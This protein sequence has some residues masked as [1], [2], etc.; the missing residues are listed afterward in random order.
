MFDPFLP[1]VREAPV[2]APVITVDEASEPPLAEPHALQNPLGAL[3]GSET[4]LVARLQVEPRKITV[5]PAIEHVIRSTT[6][7]VQTEVTVRDSRGPVRDLTQADFELFDNGV[8]QRI[9]AFSINELN[10][11]YTPAAAIMLIDRVGAFDSKT[12]CNRASVL[13][14]IL[15]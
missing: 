5:V 12:M 10:N 1:L 9:G 15:E 3:T 2:P 6:H 8:P 11:A 4:K 14:K 13:L 7:L